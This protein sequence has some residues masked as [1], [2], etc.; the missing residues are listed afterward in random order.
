MLR[1]L[2]NLAMLVLATV[3]ALLFGALILIPLALASSMAEWWSLP[4]MLVYYLI[5]TAIWVTWRERRE[6]RQSCSTS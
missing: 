5:L 2:K 3:L 1:L 4:V 6:R